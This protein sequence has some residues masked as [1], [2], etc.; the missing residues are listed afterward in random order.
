MEKRERHSL[1]VEGDFYVENEVCLAC[2][3]APNEAP[4]LMVLDEK[5]WHCY[6]KKQP[7][8][9]EEIKQAINAI[10]VSDVCALRYAGNDPRILEKLPKEFCDIFD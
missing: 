10:C 8:T 5:I 3:A 4:D 2:D 9:S 6:F 1:N 7:E